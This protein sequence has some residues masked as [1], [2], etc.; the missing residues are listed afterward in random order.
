MQFK[1]VSLGVTEKSDL[2]KKSI[3]TISN[4]IQ[5]EKTNVKNLLI[6]KISVHYEDITGNI[7]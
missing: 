2:K 7:E 5:K 6:K 1:W 4:I 3:V